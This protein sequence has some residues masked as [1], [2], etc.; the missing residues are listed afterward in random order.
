MSKNNKAKTAGKFIVLMLC[1]AILFFLL[2]PFLDNPDAV[3]GEKKK[4]AVPQI[5]TSN[6][7]SD[8]V[9]KVY[10]LFSRGQRRDPAHL[11]AKDLLA[12]GT[13]RPGL[14]PDARYSVPPKEKG[15]S[16]T[17]SA[18]AEENEEEYGQAALINE[19]G[20]WILVRQ[21]APVAFQR[22]MHEV[23]SSDSAYDKYAGLQI[24]SKYTA[25]PVHH[26]P[27]SKWTRLWNPLKRFLGWDEQ[28]AN[29]DDSEAMFLAA[30]RPSA[31][32]IVESGPKTPSATPRPG[33]GGGNAWDA[34]IGGGQK[35]LAPAPEGISLLDLFDIES[36]T[37]RLTRSAEDWYPAG[38]DGTL[39]TQATADRQREREIVR[40]RIQR[41]KN[42]MAAQ[43]QQDAQ[44]EEPLSL[45]QTIHCNQSRATYKKEDSTCAPPSF[46]SPN[47]KMKEKGKEAAE[48]ARKTSQMNLADELNFALPLSMQMNMVVVFG[49]DIPPHYDAAANDE[50]EEDGTASDATLTKEAYSFLAEN[51]CG[52]GEHCFWVGTDSK[53]AIAA[54]IPIYAAGANYLPDPLHLNQGN[55]ASFKKYKLEKA[56]QEGKSEQ[57]IQA[58]ANQ[59][60]QLSMPFTAYNDQEWSRLQQR[61]KLPPP[62]DAKRSA[63]PEE[64]KDSPFLTVV[65]TAPNAQVVVNMSERP[66]MVLYDPDNKFLNGDTGGSPI[67]QGE[68]LNKIMVERIRIVKNEMRELE[69]ELS[70]MRM[71]NTVGRQ[72]D[73]MREELYQKSRAMDQLKAEAQREIERSRQ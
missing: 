46:N 33:F 65:P 40:Q 50:L 37:E 10:A 38:K 58:L 14:A 55:L 1:F 7:L 42:L 24:S 27:Q 11:A 69:K 72:A 12:A 8:L 18:S 68:K 29:L 67:E 64:P 59:L 48:E 73:A 52:Q 32:G 4:K 53:N 62:P 16:F 49:D 30:A 21:T 9:R 54:K 15:N 22:G 26:Y 35:N 43:V 56:K 66:G 36:A 2:L 6:P 28:N 47:A 17:F 41:M 60:D 25:H 63:P 44:G 51:H 70:Q 23:N 61:N 20:E 5:F 39:S 57:E 34:R 13:P 45:N 71:K 31:E 19:D 3:S